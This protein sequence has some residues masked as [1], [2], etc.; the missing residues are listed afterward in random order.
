M[1]DLDFY[2]N[3]KLLNEITKDHLEPA[4]MREATKRVVKILDSKYEKAN[5]AEV[6]NEHC[7]HLSVK[8]RIDLLC[9]LTEFETMFDGT[10]GDFKTSPVHL[11]LK[12]GATPYH[13]RPYPVPM[14]Q[15][16][17][18]KKEV[19]RLE[20]I[21]VLKRQPESEWASPSFPV[22]KK[23]QTVRFISDFREVNKRLVRTPFPIPKISTVLQ[24][25]EGFTYATALDLNMGYYT[26]RLDPDSQKICTCLLYTSPSPRDS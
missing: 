15:R 21:G 6:V 9:L 16:E 10:L 26:I 14:S 25:M 24:E 18:L 8:E 5:L 17:M 3:E 19:D 4:S 11:R 1:K 7:Q 2:R 13:G 20:K 22:P 23:N 12:P